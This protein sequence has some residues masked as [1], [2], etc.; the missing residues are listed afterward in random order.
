MLSQRPSTYSATN[1]KTPTEPATQRKGGRAEGPAPPS[2]ELRP[3]PEKAEPATR[4]RI[5]SQQPKEKG[6]GLKARPP[7]LATPVWGPSFFSFPFK[8]GGR[9]TRRQSGPCRFWSRKTDHF[10]VQIFADF[11]PLF[12]PFF[13]LPPLQI[14]GP[15]DSPT[16]RA[17]STLEQEKMDHFWVSFLV[18]FGPFFC[19]AIFSSDCLRPGEQTS[20]LSQRPLC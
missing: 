9:E 2:S 7:S 10:L 16:V 20:M 8:L 3:R 13:F 1:Q 6:A 19:L 11:G 18:D 17:L 14:R 5:L 4:R 12:G 15:R